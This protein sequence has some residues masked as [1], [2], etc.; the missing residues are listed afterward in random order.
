[1]FAACGRDA[2]RLNVRSWLALGILAASVGM[3]WFGRDKTKV[4]SDEQDRELAR[5]A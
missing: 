1:L 3:E 5:A 4:E 2:G